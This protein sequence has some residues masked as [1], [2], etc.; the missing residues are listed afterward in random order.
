VAGKWGDRSVFKRPKSI[1]AE[2][3]RGRARRAKGGIDDRMRGRLRGK[4]ELEQRIGQVITPL[5]T[6]HGT[7]GERAGI[8]RHP[9]AGGVELPK[10]LSKKYE[11]RGIF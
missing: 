10:V 4:K 9:S 1:T 11:G 2:P 3:G 8:E 7:D 5:K 6:L